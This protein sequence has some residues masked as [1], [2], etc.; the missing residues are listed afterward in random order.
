MKKLLVVATVLVAG[1]VSAKGTT[2]KTIV[3]KE[4]ELFAKQNLLLQQNKV[5][6]DLVPVNTWCG[7]TF[8]LDKNNYSDALE[9]AK[10]ANEFAQQQCEEF[11]YWN[12]SN[13]NNSLT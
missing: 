5:L 1:M 7:K 9:L 8:Y 12:C 11:D 3:E 4:K 6:Y 2:G 13:T 10:A